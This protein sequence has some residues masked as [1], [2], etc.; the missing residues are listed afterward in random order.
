[1]NDEFNKPDAQT[2]TEENNVKAEAADWAPSVDEVDP[3]DQDEAD[4]IRRPKKKKRSAFSRLRPLIGLFLLA[5]AIT[6]A[7]ALMPKVKI[8]DIKEWIQSN[9][10]G[11][12][13]GDGFPVSYDGSPIDY[14]NFTLNDDSPAALSDTT[15]LHLSNGGRTVS[16]RQHSFFSPTM[17]RNGDAFLLYDAGSKSYCTSTDGENFSDVKTYGYAIYSA[18]IL[19]NGTYALSSSA[20]GFASQV[21][22]Y[23]RIGTQIFR[24]ASQEYR[25]TALA[26]DPTG[27][28]L[29]AAGFTAENGTLVSVVQLFSIHQAEALATFTEE[30]N[31]ILNMVFQSEDRLAVVG[32]KA[33]SVYTTA[34][35]VNTYAYTSSL[36]HYD[37]DRVGGIALDVSNYGDT[38]RGTLWVMD[39]DGQ[40][41]NIAR[42]VHPV[43]SVDMTN[44]GILVMYEDQLQ[45]LAL[46]GS[47]RYT[48]SNI[49]DGIRALL[50]SDSESAFIL[51]HSQIQ[52]ISLTDK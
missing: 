14:G 5:L 7:L 29:A 33:A 42:Y 41:K 16:L 22:V 8:S 44:D 24:W 43:E 28:R 26:F 10:L 25:I 4:A 45:L 31:L 30:D 9:L 36:L 19:E 20:D 32:D 51:G 39:W 50:A 47:I 27:K 46:N 40:T 15:F 13:D 52:R 48:V 34:G 35:L 17:V 38:R 18:A 2:E 23:D 3:Y 11:Y 21:I 49:F 1:M 6:V 37:I 12:H